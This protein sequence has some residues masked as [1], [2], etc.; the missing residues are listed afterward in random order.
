MA[1]S[2]HTIAARLNRIGI[3]ILNIKPQDDWLQTDACIRMTSEWHISIGD[4]IHLGRGNKDGT[5]TLWP[6]ES[7]G[8][9]E[10]RIKELCGF[11]S[12]VV[13]NHE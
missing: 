1:Y 10:Y 13:L 7:V 6:C 5:F 12:I 11:R 4:F 3:P 2:V 8:H 9:L